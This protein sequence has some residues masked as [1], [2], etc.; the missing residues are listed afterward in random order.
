MSAGITAVSPQCVQMRGKG[1]VFAMD[2]PITSSHI[3]DT[4]GAIVIL[5]AAEITANCI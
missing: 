3:V 2:E 1:F 4:N 5:R